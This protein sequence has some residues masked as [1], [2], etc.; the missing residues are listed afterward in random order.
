MTAR[1]VSALT[2][3]LL[4]TSAAA[5]R[6]SS[7][8][9]SQTH[10]DGFAQGVGGPFEH[11]LSI[12]SWNQIDTYSDVAITVS[13]NGNDP[14]YTGTA[15]LM[16]KI[17]PGTTPADEVAQASYAAVGDFVLHDIT[18][19]TGLTLV[20][21]T[22]YL[23]LSAPQSASSSIAWAGTAA[24]TAT[25]TRAP[26]V[27]GGAGLAIAQGPSPYPPAAVYNPFFEWDLTYAVTG[28]VQAVP[29]PCSLIMFAT[30]AI[31]F[32]GRIRR[33]RAA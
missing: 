21:D 10:S 23:V 12:L 7:I 33:R 32:V 22:Y 29:E 28:D 4:V 25:F 8:I 6:A 20:P 11:K 5:A 24:A 15:Y 16:T 26:G 3:A 30:G 13:L 19:F 1:A 9:I 17:G 14:S 2:I 27:S 31:G 18:L